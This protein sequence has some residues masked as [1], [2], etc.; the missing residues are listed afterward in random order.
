MFRHGIAVAGVTVHAHAL[1]F[2]PTRPRAFL[3]VFAKTQLSLFVLEFSMHA[4]DGHGVRSV[5]VVAPDRSVAPLPHAVTDLGQ[6]E[7]VQQVL[8]ET[9][10]LVDCV[11]LAVTVTWHL[12]CSVVEL[13]V[14]VELDLSG[15]ICGAVA[16]LYLLVVDLDLIVWLILFGD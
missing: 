15:S 6:V 13:R 12:W 14:V 4:N 2:L 10:V 1:P 16:L 7:L 5:T 8:V 3:G 9:G 11:V